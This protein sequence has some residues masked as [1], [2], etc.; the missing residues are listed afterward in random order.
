M[1]K[2]DWLLLAIDDRMEP[3]Q[4]QKALFKFTMESSA[5]KNELYSFIPYNWGPLSVE[6]YEDLSK[7]R[8]EK[9]IEFAPSGRGWNVYHLTEAGKGKRNK[10]REKAKPDLLDKLDIARDYV[11]SRDFETLLSDIYKKYPKYAAASLFRK[12]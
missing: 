12:N 7:L 3:I 9:L 6:I 4:I 1:N 5:P 8:E 11:T 10:L 2:C